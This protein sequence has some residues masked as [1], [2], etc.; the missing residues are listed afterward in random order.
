MLSIDYS[1][2]VGALLELGLYAYLASNPSGLIN[3]LPGIAGDIISSFDTTKKPNVIKGFDRLIQK[4]LDETLK[5]YFNKQQIIKFKEIIFSIDN[6]QEYLTDNAYDLFRKNFLDALNQLE[7]TKNQDWTLLNT[8]EILKKLLL[9]INSGIQKDSNLL[10]LDTNV[11]THLILDKIREL[12]NVSAAPVNYPKY[13]TPIE[14]FTPESILHREEE[15]NELVQR[16]LNG[17]RI[18]MI[19]SSAGLGK[20]KLARA[21]CH[22]L[23]DQFDHLAWLTYDG[24]LEN[25]LLTL[26]I[27]EQNPDPQNRLFQIKEFLNTTEKNVLIVL[28]NVNDIPNHTDLQAIAAFSP[29]VRILITS[30]LPEIKGMEVFL[31]NALSL[32]SCT[33]IFYLH[34][35]LDPNREQ[36]ET[37][38]TII[39]SVGRNTYLVELL[40][41]SA[42]A[43]GEQLN[44]VW[45]RMREHG[46]AFSHVRLATEHSTSAQTLQE[47]VK[48]LYEMAGLDEAKQRVL[49]VFSVLPHSTPI[50][51]HIKSWMPCDINDLI[52]LVE[53]GWLQQNE[54]G[55]TMHQLLQESIRLQTRATLEDCQGLIDSFTQKEFI[56]GD[57]PYTEKGKRINYAD[58]LIEFFQPIPESADFSLLLN[59]TAYNHH[60]YLG[61]FPQAMNYYQK[62]LAI[63]EKVLGSEHPDTAASYNNIGLLYHDQGDYPQ[64]LNYYQKALSIREKVLGMEHPGTAR[65]YNNIG[66]L[67]KVQGDFSKALSY[68]QKALAIYEKVLGL[69]HPDTAASYENIGML[70]RNQGDFLQALRYNQKALAIYE[71]VLGPEHPDTA[72]SYNNIGIIYYDQG[73]FFQAMNYYQKALAIK[74]KVLGLGH[75]DTASSY[76]NIGTLYRD[77]GDFTQAL[78][79][80]FKAYRILKYKLN[81]NHFHLQRLYKNLKLTYEK[82]AAFTEPFEEWLEKALESEN[83]NFPD[84]S[85]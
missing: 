68:Y 35:K 54:L 66:I 19:S 30:R 59:K 69:E 48:A 53:R 47:H 74:E 49:R 1:N 70:Y 15:T 73:D 58:S 65:S 79:F 28:D 18:V 40:A 32:E 39:N 81:P 78:E 80:L 56:S 3:I 57:L 46:F 38:Q 16:L 55:Y 25:Q 67:Y 36:R 62:A 22:S 61:D 17:Q 2:I 34:Y 24:S 10:I 84:S 4:S 23:E 82:S 9:N 43:E 7:P 14:L 8:D 50:S 41:R 12:Q 27:L 21:V 13:L 72:R 6:M 11:N 85:S 51:V 83:V 20:T 5:P 44:N 42:Q 31:L 76:N 45:E 71:K 75:P 29:S 64:A 60:F 33:D 77:Q 52:W 63:R 26:R 37:A